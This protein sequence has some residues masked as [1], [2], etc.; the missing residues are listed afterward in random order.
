MSWKGNKYVVYLEF[1]EAIAKSCDKEHVAAFDID[2]TLI[3]SKNKHAKTADDWKFLYEWVP[4]TLKE[5]SLTNTIVCFSN[6]SLINKPDRLKMIKERFTTFASS[7]KIP[8]ILYVSLGNTPFRKPDTGMVDLFLQQS[9]KKLGDI[10]FYVGD[11]AGRVYTKTKKDFS[12]SDYRLAE[13]MGVKFH[14]PECYFDNEF[15]GEPTITGFVPKR[16]SKSEAEKCRFDYKFPDPVKHPHVIMMMG[17]PGS[18]KS[19]FISQHID[20]AVYTVIE[21]DKIRGK[22]NIPI[23]DNGK[24]KKSIVLDGVH[25]TDSSRNKSFSK[26]PEDAN[27]YCVYLEMSMEEAIHRDRYRTNKMFYS[28]AGP[29][30]SRPILNRISIIA[31][32]TFRKNFVPPTIE[33][34]FTEIIKYYPYIE[35]D[36]Y[37]RL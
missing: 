9:G 25:M 16:K 20:S 10:T 29:I 7:L 22:I 18:G 35:N 23:D 13:N 3:R 21:F 31:Y 24:L 37:Y 26:I 36:L 15:K 28:N 1:M 12:D 32:R 8:I 30:L 27:I 4:D 11:A 33:E 34:G 6:Q 14:T 19:T 2:W 17:Y 5:L